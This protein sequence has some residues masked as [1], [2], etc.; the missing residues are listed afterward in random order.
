MHDNA[1]NG[2][3]QLLENV[4]CAIV[5]AQFVR[6]WKHWLLRPGEVPR[7]ESV[8]NSAFICEHGL[9]SLDPNASSDLDSTVAII[10]RGDWDLLQ[11]LYALFASLLISS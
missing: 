11:D 3:T 2:N 5:S 7:P 1:L 8:D 10:K 9:L 4:P 6:T